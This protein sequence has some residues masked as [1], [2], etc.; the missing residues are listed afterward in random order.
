MGSDAAECRS[1]GWNVLTFTLRSNKETP[2]HDN[3]LQYHKNLRDIVST[4]LWKIK[5]IKREAIE[6]LVLTHTLCTCVNTRK[7]KGPAVPS[8]RK[9]ANKEGR[10]FTQN[11]LRR[12]C[13][14]PTV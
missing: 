7:S 5:A 12:P 10:D 14:G 8:T 4:I 11:H 2:P 1:P 3:T 6:V 9:N 13:R